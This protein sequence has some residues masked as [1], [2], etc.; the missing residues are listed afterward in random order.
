MRLYHMAE[1]TFRKKT[2]NRWVVRYLG[3]GHRMRLVVRGGR[4]LTLQLFRLVLRPSRLSSRCRAILGACSIIVIIAAFEAV[5]ALA[6]GGVGGAGNGCPGGAGGAGGAGLTGNPGAPG[7]ACN[8]GGGGGGA[9]GG[10]GGAGGATAGGA[11]GGGGTNTTVTGTIANTS[12]LIGGNGAAG[13]DGTSTTVSPSGG[14]G[15]GAGGLGAEVTGTGLSSNFGRII[16][17]RGGDGGNGATGSLG[18]AGGGGGGAGDGGSAVLFTAGTVAFTNATAG[19]IIGGNGGNGGAGGGLFRSCCALGGDGGIGGAGVQFLGATVMF[20]N[21]GT[22]IGGN[23]G[24]GSLGG[25]AGH[26]GDA[27]LL[28][29]S[30]AT[31]N[32]SGRLLG[33][34]GGTGSTPLSLGGLLPTTGTVGGTGGAGVSFMAGAAAFNNSGT[35]IGGNGGLGGLAP[36]LVGAAGSGGDGG[37]GAQ[38]SAGGLL[39]NSGVILGGNGAA[40]RPTQ[41]GFT[42]A[43]GGGGIGILG[44]DLTIINSGTISGG[45]SGDGSTRAT[46]I[47]FTGGLN[48]LELQAGSTINGNV[49]AFS[50]ADTLRLGG[51]SN[52]T[53]DVS[54]IGSQYLGFGVLQKGGSSTWTLT[55]TNSA[56]TPWTIA[57]GTLQVNAAIANAP[58]TVNGTAT[59]AGTGTIGGLTV[60]NGA[61]FMPGTQGVSGTMTITANLAFQ[62]GAIYLV[63]LTAAGGSRA[64]VGGTSAFVGTL[65]IVFLSPSLTRSSSLLSSAGGVSGTFDSVQLVNLPAGFT[66]SVA[67]TPTEV[68][69]NLNGSLATAGLSANQRQVAA[70]I[71]TAFANGNTLPAPVVGL[72]GL[73][74]PSLAN[75]LQMITGEAATG[76]QQA[77][78]GA[79][80]QFMGIISD[81]F[82]VR[83]GMGSQPG[84]SAFAAEAGSNAYAATKRTDAFAMAAK[85]PPAPPVASWSVWAAGFGGS[86]SVDG[87]AVTGANNATS[88]IYGTAVG[89]DYLIT[90]YTL[91]GFALAG[92]G[93]NFDVRGQGSG[94][95]DLFQA[96]AYLRHRSG[97]AYVAAAL[98]YAWQDITTDRIVTIAGADHLRAEFNANAYS[99]RLEGGY[100]FA[101]PWTLGIGLTPYAAAQFTT[102]DLPAYAERAVS[103]TSNFA[104]AYGAKSV[105]DPRSELGLRTDGSFAVPQGVVTLRGRVAW[106][107]DF[108]PNRA[109]A[110]SFQSLPAAG[111]V[112]NGAAQACD[113]ALTTA[114]VEMRWSNGWSAAATFE[115]E[116][117]N[118]TRSYAGK[119]VVRYAW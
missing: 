115:G 90:P 29:G 16:G 91:A 99:G 61:V 59:L 96:G 65:D 66:A 107:H 60:H 104:L 51:I 3:R 102:F 17:G 19:T 71:N 92:G 33:G 83:G 103:G 25:A 82:F 53:F 113:S 11:G 7:G 64:Q 28:A 54:Q 13:A 118:V 89:A 116:F 4:R 85:A 15:G 10:A 48:V 42:P 26:G 40:A 88:S 111:F 9:G 63:Q 46:A 105:T 108:N 101:A 77:T 39:S 36:G 86:Q 49:V 98:A 87:N 52:A 24:D 95:S 44:R 79:M 76:A 75:A 72:F 57:A 47:S 106:A 110:A 38:F 50:A 119:G 80:N 94:R 74:A 18:G 84:A 34:N 2:I 97:P 35:V 62:S 69:L 22:A 68:V 21:L 23:G 30:S 100:R 6:D 27:A 117:S 5:P 12:T 109:I 81:P 20:A 73:S 32:N 58:I 93:T 14:G 55:G 70:A 41:A 56:S 67:Y 45:Q 37:V 31:L 78:F 43:A 112:V 1:F 8:A 114:A